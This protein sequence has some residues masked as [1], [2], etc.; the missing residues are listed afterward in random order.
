VERLTDPSCAVLT[1]ARPQWYRPD[2]GG[3]DDSQP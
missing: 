2:R 3:N 1:Y